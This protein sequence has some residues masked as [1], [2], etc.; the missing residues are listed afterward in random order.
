M[1]SRYRVIFLVWIILCSIF[2]A[3]AESAFDEFKAAVAIDKNGLKLPPTNAFELIQ[4]I[5]YAIDTELF[6]DDSFFEPEN[7]LL[8]TNAKSVEGTGKNANWLM[9]RQVNI[10]GVQRTIEVVRAN[11]ANEKMGRL[12][13]SFFSPE[14]NADYIIKALGPITTTR[15]PYI[16]SG[17]GH[18][19]PLSA[20]THLL[21]NMEICQ[22]FLNKKISTKVCSLTSGS[23]QVSQ[24]NVVQIKGN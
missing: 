15:D 6:L 19:M 12:V 17:T 24:F 11:T 5:K 23:G 3:M 1:K 4:N 10:E 13:I 22:S 7:L 20:K 18:P 2:P 16:N 8:F 9:I 21:G 14:I